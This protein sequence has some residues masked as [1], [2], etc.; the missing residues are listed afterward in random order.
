MS[1]FRN[2][3]K[4]SND[5]NLSEKLEM[6]C[7]HFDS[8][9]HAVKIW[10][11]WSR[12]GQVIRLQNYIDFLK[13]QAHMRLKKALYITWLISASSILL[14]ISASWI[15]VKISTKDKSVT[16]IIS[17]FR[18][19]IILERQGESLTTVPYHQSSK[20]SP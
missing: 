11:H 6:L 19:Y 9:L 5:M 14:C 10:D 3:L 8:F 18:G 1:I 20:Y 13:H 4:T 7:G 16:V 12:I 2:T 17:F 15:L